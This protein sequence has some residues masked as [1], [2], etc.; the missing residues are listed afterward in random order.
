MNIAK[1]IDG[2]LVVAD[3]REMFKETS[4]PVTGPNDDFFT[5]NNCFKVSVFKEHDRATQMIV[6]CGAYEENGVVY[7][8]E[9]QTRPEPIIQTITIEALADSISGGVS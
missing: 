9:V 6:G 2:Q 8:V 3:Y 7:T 5:E 1:L 4:F